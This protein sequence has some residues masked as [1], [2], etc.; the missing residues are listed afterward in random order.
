[1]GLCLAIF[2]DNFQAKYYSGEFVCKVHIY[3]KICI[4]LLPLAGQSPLI[5]GGWGGKEQL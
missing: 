4:F 1:M 3:S 2:I 5:V